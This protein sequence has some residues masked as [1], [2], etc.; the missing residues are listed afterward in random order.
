VKAL[1]GSVTTA[2]A[3]RFAHHVL[4]LNTNE[5]I[6]TYLTARLHEVGGN[7]ELLDTT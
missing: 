6:R 1:L 7:L 5:E 4:Q 2:Q 3:E